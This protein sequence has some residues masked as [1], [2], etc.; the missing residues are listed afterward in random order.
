MLTWLA[1]GVELMTDV[2]P[3][4]WVVQRLRPWAGDGARLESFAPD[5][6][7]GYARVIHPASTGE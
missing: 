6:F 7:D 3:A 4:D 1:P 5:G 2:S